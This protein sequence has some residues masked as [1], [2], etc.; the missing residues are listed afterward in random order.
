MWYDDL[1]VS[2]L[3]NFGSIITGLSPGCVHYIMFLGNTLF[4]LTV[5]QEKLQLQGSGGGGG[6]HGIS[7]DGDDQ[8]IFGL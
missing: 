2:T 5:P 8:R 4:A 7:S 1:I 6:V 3:M